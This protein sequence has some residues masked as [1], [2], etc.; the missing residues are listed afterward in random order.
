[1]IIRNTWAKG[2]L[3]R[4]QNSH[5]FINFLTN[6]QYRDLWQLTIWICKGK[7][8]SLA[9]LKNFLW[10]N[11]VLSCQRVWEQK[12]FGNAYSS[13]TYI[14]MQTFLWNVLFRFAKNIQICKSTPLKIKSK[15]LH[16]IDFHAYL[17]HSGSNLWIV[18][19]KKLHIFSFW[20]QIQ[21][22]NKIDKS[23]WIFDNFKTV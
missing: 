21:N 18:V 3:V 7:N 6:T 1:M 22:L 2:Q 19:H 11:L 17:K 10:V 14:Q 12:H 9:I 5:F 15:N 20:D 13:K 16:R 23:I 8:L 4:F